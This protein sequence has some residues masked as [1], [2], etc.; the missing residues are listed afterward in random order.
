MQ[1]TL[2]PILD[3]S[4]LKGSGFCWLPLIG[5]DGRASSSKEN[6][7]QYFQYNVFIPG[8]TPAFVRLPSELHESPALFY[9]FSQDFPGGNKA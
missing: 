6:I 7:W 4:S 2:D 8:H 3:P 9:L 1:P 5:D